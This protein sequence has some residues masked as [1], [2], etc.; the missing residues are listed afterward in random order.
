M[1]GE[2]ISEG[3][4]SSMWKEMTNKPMPKIEVLIVGND[5]YNR[6]FGR[7]RYYL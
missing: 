6:I 1:I 5:R 4:V 7:K 3:M 2:R